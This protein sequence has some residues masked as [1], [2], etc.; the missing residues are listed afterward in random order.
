MKKEAI[1]PVKKKFWRIHSRT[2][3]HDK[4]QRA[5]HKCPEG[6]LTVTLQV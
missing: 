5:I 3:Q 4:Y 2:I 6:L 1:F